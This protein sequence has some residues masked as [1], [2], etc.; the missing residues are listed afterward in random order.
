MYL[1]DT[2]V[3]MHLANGAYGA[4]PIERPGLALVTDNT[5]H[6]D[7]IAPLKTENWRE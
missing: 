7:G 2:K 1:V 3:F 6:F 4:E 5:R